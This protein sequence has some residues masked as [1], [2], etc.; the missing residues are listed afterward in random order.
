MS[1]I[2]WAALPIGLKKTE[3]RLEAV[4]C[5]PWHL[6]AQHVG[7]ENL[8][9]AVQLR[10]SLPSAVRQSGSAGGAAMP[11]TRLLGS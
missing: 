5:S 10:G 1:G 2:C 7:I 3:C 4:S 8:T 6:V 9:S 11:P